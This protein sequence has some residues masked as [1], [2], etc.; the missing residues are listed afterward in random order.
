M[1]RKLTDSFSPGTG[2]VVGRVAHTPHFFASTSPA[3]WWCAGASILSCWQ[4]SHQDWKSRCWG[5][6]QGLWWSSSGSP[7]SPCMYSTKEQDTRAFDQGIL[8]LGNKAIVQYLPVSSGATDHFPLSF[9]GFSSFSNLRLLITSSHGPSTSSFA[10]WLHRQASSSLMALSTTCPTAWTYLWPPNFYTGQ[11]KVTF[12]CLVRDPKPIPN[13]LP[14]NLPLGGTSILPVTWAHT[15]TWVTPNSWLSSHS[16]LSANYW[17]HFQN[18]SRSCPLL[19]SLLLPSHSR[20]WLPI[21]L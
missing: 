18:R 4:R 14:Y 15:S 2:R 9:A 20:P 10:S 5:W 21:I 16:N 17:S 3:A 19:M 13:L 1:H 12:W 7:D 6:C 8:S 11:L